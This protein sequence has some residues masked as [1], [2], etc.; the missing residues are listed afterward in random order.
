[1]H[2]KIGETFHG[3]ISGVHNFGLFVELNDIHIS[4]L[5]HITAL[6]KDYF[7]YD[8]IRHQLNGERSG[9]QYRLGDAMNVQL[10]AVD[11][12]ER[13]IDFVLVTTSTGPASKPKKKR[14]A[15]KHV[16]KIVRLPVL[17]TPRRLPI[18]SP[19]SMPSAPYC[20]M[21]QNV[22][23]ACMSTA[24][25]KT[26]DYKIYWLLP[27]KI[28]YHVQV[29]DTEAL[30]KLLGNLNHQGVAAL[31]SLPVPG[32]ETTLDELLCNQD[33]PAFLLVL[34]SIT[35]PHNLGACLRAADAA[36]VQA[37]IAPRDKATGLTPTACK[38]ASGAAET[39][40]FIQ[41]TNLARTLRH[42]Q[43]QHGVFISGLAR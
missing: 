9:K 10:A 4:G 38:V 11:P 26:D 23:I 18:G 34:D 43:D 30:Q 2:D 32:N 6:D 33:D 35:D 40:N 31:T 12:A 5:V 1:M 15:R 27:K 22:S 7:H 29:S 42:L 19:E 13:R 25:G 21:V 14:R 28:R 20:C 17:K 3:V 41:V 8:P 39:V 24:S 36:G 16:K 37:V